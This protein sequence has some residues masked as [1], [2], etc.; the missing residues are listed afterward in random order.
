MRIGVDFDTTIV[1]Y[2]ALF[3]RVAVE[4]GLIPVDLPQT[5]LSVRDHLR[6][7]DREDIW[8]EM[9]GHVYGARMDEAAAYPGA[10]DFFTWARAE[11]LDLVIVSHKTRRPFLGQE[12]DL[13]EAARDWVRKFLVAQPLIDEA[14]VYFELTREE[15]LARIAALELDYFIDDLPEIFLAAEFPART[16]GLLFDPDGALAGDGRVPAFR[17]WQQ[18]R[19]HIETQWTK[20]R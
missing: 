8:T 3:H 10:I 17:S 11:G 7:T 19:H 4:R 15:K 1:S 13:H 12:Y 18:L 9:Q 6:R 16:T 5:K 14:D 20:R 2:E